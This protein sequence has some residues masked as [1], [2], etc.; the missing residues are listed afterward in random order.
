MHLVLSRPTGVEVLPTLFTPTGHRLD[1][2]MQEF[3]Q[4]VDAEK[5]ARL[6][7]E[8]HAQDMQHEAA[9]ARAWA[10]SQVPYRDGFHMPLRSSQCC[11]QASICCMMHL[12]EHT[13]KCGSALVRPV[14][15][16][17]CS[18]ARGRR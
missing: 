4:L 6:D 7:A 12:P 8:T 10:S 1:A 11:A 5:Q 17:Y 15:I 13:R 2:H 14:V 18:L 9:T 16:T 3:A